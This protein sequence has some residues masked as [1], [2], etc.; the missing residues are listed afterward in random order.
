MIDEQHKHD[1]QIHYT[2]V[3]WQNPVFI[4]CSD[5]RCGSSYYVARKPVLIAAERL[6]NAAEDIL[7]TE[8]TAKDW[9]EFLNAWQAYVDV[10]PEEEDNIDPADTDTPGNPS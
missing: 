3:D 4:K 7:H 9:E 10:A 6:A 8:H 2:A 5:Y 1:F